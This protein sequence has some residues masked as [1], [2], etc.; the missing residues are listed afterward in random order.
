MR[1]RIGKARTAS[2]IIKKVL[3]S[4]E[5]RKSIK[6]R[7]INTTV[8]SITFYGSETWIMTNPTL[9]KLQ[10]FVNSCQRKILCIRWPEKIGNEHM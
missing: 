5:I 1:A 3:S 8:K 9:H 4:K 7:I 6:L 2:L 10:T